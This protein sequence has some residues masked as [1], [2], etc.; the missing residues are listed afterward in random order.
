MGGTRIGDGAIV[1]MNSH[2]FGDIPAYSIYSGNPAKFLKFRFEQN[3]IDA[4]IELKWWSYQHE[5]ILEIVP[6][7]CQAPTEKL[8][9]EINQ[10]LS[11]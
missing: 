11:N 10:I 7:L 4:L 9:S 5:R 8:I 2:V 3:I 1:G 6:K